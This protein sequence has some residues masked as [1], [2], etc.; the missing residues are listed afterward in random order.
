[1]KSE[2]AQVQKAFEELGLKLAARKVEKEW[3]SGAFCFAKK[4]F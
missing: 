2:F 4:Y 3:C 1:L